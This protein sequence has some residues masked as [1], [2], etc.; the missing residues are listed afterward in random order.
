VTAAVVFDFDG[1]LADTE[2]LHLQAYQDVLG[3]LGV[4]L[5]REAY[6]ERY[7]GFDDD[8]VFRSSPSIADRPSR[9]GRWRG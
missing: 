1:V 3:P 5:T 6:Y 8:G 7:L 9:T 2:P 4:T